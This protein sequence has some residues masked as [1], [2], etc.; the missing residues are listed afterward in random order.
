MSPESNRLVNESSPY[1][2]QHAWNPVDWYPWGEEALERARTENRPIFLSIGYSSCHWCHVMER[3]SFEDPHIAR[4]L[5]K[6]FVNIKVDREERP[7]V[8][9]VY[10]EA[11]QM[12]TGQGGWPLNVWLTPDQ[13]PIFAGTYFP[14]QDHHGRPGFASVIT[15][16]AE[17]YR[18]HPEKIKQQT[19]EMQKALA[20]DIY[21][22]LSPGS[23][24]PELL[25]RAFEGYANAFD[26][27]DGG[28]SAAP[29]FPTAM[30]I[31]FLLRYGHSTDS[32]QALRMAL[33]SLEKMISGG[34]YDQV[35]GGFHRYS[36]DKKWLVPHF[37]KMLYD[38]ALLLPV[39]AEAA[40]ITGRELFSRTVD[41]TITFLNREMRHPGGAYYSALD[42][43]TEGVEG[44]FYIFSHDEVAQLLE[45]DD[46]E[47]VAAHYG[48]E[49]GGNWEGVSV[50]HRA[51][52]LD[53]LAKRHGTGE[54][55]LQTR[56]DAAK[57]SLL[58]YRNRR[59]RPGLDDKIIT[60]WNALM[61]IALCR[62]S[63]LLDR[64]AGDAIRLGSFLAEHA[65]RDDTLYR[66]IDRDGKAKQPGFLDD[67][68]L[69]ADGF[70][71]LFELTGDIQWLTLSARLVQLMI[72]RFYDDEKSAFRYTSKQNEQLVAQ[73]RDIFDNAQPGG[74]TAAVTALQRVGH[75]AGIPDWTRLAVTAM[76]P[77]AEPASTH[78]TAFGYL[79]QA[80]HQHLHPGRE[81]VIATG[82]TPSDQTPSSQTPSGQ[83]PS[84]QSPSGQTPSGQITSGRSGTEPLNDGGTVT[85]RMLDIWRS[86]YDPSSFV[87]VLSAEHRKKIDTPTPGGKTDPSDIAGR[88]SGQIEQLYGNKTAIDKKTT[89]YVCKDF[90]CSAPVQ[91]IGHFKQEIHSDK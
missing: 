72:E 40:Q 73:T 46:F 47:L 76:E 14:P 83:T 31:G 13:I 1:L 38:N 21:D 60:S 51:V 56:L 10:M 22:R 81:I 24:T 91:T 75:L 50:L 5:N 57:S 79:L 86:R 28:F 74:S 70:S 88:Y 42:A 17:V 85:R 37:E 3:E 26:G 58:E 64:D 89:A 78:P 30:G 80:M 16:L 19:Q 6:H 77:L 32:D 66:I 63:R 48:I 35:G 12:M 29:K 4:L 44:K 18:S 11:L 82:Q 67:Y 59:E 43:D 34:I 49:P 45:K 27:E 7:D 23:I 9:A 65:V 33:F 87:I 54:Q 15:R 62:C 25:D 2:Q 36:T 8:D 39:L 41:E 53:E 69:L 20:N 61:L 52:P 71:R 84:G 90:Q 55:Q 68:A